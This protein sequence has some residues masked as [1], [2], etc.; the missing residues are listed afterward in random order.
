MVGG[1]ES[2]A[3]IVEYVLLGQAL[4]REIE[5]A[6]S[7]ALIYPAA[8]RVLAPVRLATSSAR[9]LSPATH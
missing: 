8:D 2:A 7:R 4:R 9:H 3:A 5:C 6:P 1:L